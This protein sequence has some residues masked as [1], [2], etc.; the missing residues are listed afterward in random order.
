V[1]RFQRP[2]ATACRFYTRVFHAV[3]IKRHGTCRPR[4]L[5]NLVAR[6]FT[7]C[8]VLS[9]LACFAQAAYAQNTNAQ[10][11]N[12]AAT[13][14]YD[15][16]NQ[17]S[18]DTNN[19]VVVTEP[20]STNPLATPGTVPATLGVPPTGGFFLNSPTT[21][22]NVPV[23][24]GIATSG[25]IP[26]AQGI[27]ATQGA[28]STGHFESHGI[29]GLRLEASSQNMYNDNFQ[30]LAK[31]APTNGTTRSDFITTNSIDGSGTAD[32]GRQQLF[33]LG[34]FGQ[35]N[36]LRNTQFNG[37][38]LSFAGGIKWQVTSR[39]SGDLQ[40]GI[41]TN[42]Q[43]DFA[44]L[45]TPVVNS[46]QT[47][48]Y[49]AS[50][51]CDIGHGFSVTLQGQRQESTNS[52][53]TLQISN[54]DQNSAKTKFLYGQPNIGSI[55]PELSYIES[56]YPAQS[57]T[58]REYDAGLFLERRL[59]QKT[60]FS[61]EFGVARIASGTPSVTAGAPSVG[62]GT[63]GTSYQPYADA[64]VVWT[65]TAKTS[66]SLAIDHR[67][68]N[69]T[70]VVSSFA[71]T[72][73]ATVA[74]TWIISPKVSAFETFSYSLID[75]S[76]GSTA[77]ATLQQT[78]NTREAINVL[79]LNYNFTQMLTFNLQYLL[80]TQRS[81]QAGQGGSFTSNAGVLGLRLVY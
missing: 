70:S 66:L 69:S 77:S 30:D 79:S 52:N 47:V 61:A 51:L 25:G 44:Q 63:P 76:G 45:A 80:T 48:N 73:T 40:S 56:T 10:N 13:S 31:N 55:G 71:T 21:P 15:T 1:S 5:T 35:V 3:G 74:G 22:A 34:S 41:A 17:P 54:L 26:T 57:F 14:P 46:V 39:C 7:I 67:V 18:S 58:T 78:G 72:S 53:A 28:A 6:S 42:Q 24:Q 43:S 2:R 62:S 11:T 81:S 27:A 20:N 64:S 4:A 60:H 68:T 36:Y 8:G 23:A 33:I 50:G 19:P 59:F 12:P 37:N 38:P 29:F 16:T 49:E 32:V 75:Y 9:F 65:P